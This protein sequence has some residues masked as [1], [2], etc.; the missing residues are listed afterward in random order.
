MALAY[1]PHAD[2][3]ATNLVTGPPAALLEVTDMLGTHSQAAWEESFRA[4]VETSAADMGAIITSL[5]LASSFRNQRP[6]YANAYFVAARDLIDNVKVSYPTIG[7]YTLYTYVDFLVRL[8]ENDPTPGVGKRIMFNY[9]V[10]TTIFN[11]Y[12]PYSGLVGAPG[13]AWSVTNF[14]IYVNFFPGDSDPLAGTGPIGEDFRLAND[15][16]VVASGSSH[17]GDAFDVNYTWVESTGNY[18]TRTSIN[19]SDYDMNEALNPA[20]EAPP[21]TPAQIEAAKQIKRDE[22]DA[23]FGGLVEVDWNLPYWTA[24]YVATKLH[25]LA[26]VYAMRGH[27]ELFYSDAF[28]GR[29]RDI[30][31]TAEATFTLAGN[32]TFFGAFKWF[33][34]QYYNDATPLIRKTYKMVWFDGAAID[35]T[36]PA[37]TPAALNTVSTFYPIDTAVGLRPDVTTGT[38]GTDNPATDEV[39]ICYDKSIVPVTQFADAFDVRMGLEGSIVVD[40]IMVDHTAALELLYDNAST[41]AAMHDLMKFYNHPL[42]IFKDLFFDELKEA[43]NTILSSPLPI[44]PESG[45]VFYTDITDTY[46]DDPSSLPTLV[47]LCCITSTNTSDCTELPAYEVLLITYVS[48]ISYLGQ[49]EVETRKSLNLSDVVHE[50]TDSFLSGDVKAQR[51]WDRS[52]PLL[53]TIASIDTVTPLMMELVAEY[54]DTD[55]DYKF[56]FFLKLKE[57]AEVYVVVSTPTDATLYDFILLMINYCLVSPQLLPYPAELCVYVRSTTNDLVCSGLSA[58]NSILYIYPID[59]SATELV[60]VSDSKS[61]LPPNTVIAE[62]TAKPATNNTGLYLIGGAVVI[63]II[64]V[65][66]VAANQAKTEDNSYS[67]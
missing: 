8:Y 29:C 40:L 25:D 47:E 13:S 27:I 26:V 49:V 41:I 34:E 3:L 32:N 24:G 38:T 17:T 44:V 59:V 58:F 64:V 11:A 48:T 46:I 65:A 30:I 9:S 19:P 67:T 62:P 43:L 5:N 35:T 21:L 54:N 22:A 20:P 36:T 61:A 42:A 14:N 10:G 63:G 57:L 7:G 31:T 6:D 4:G 37:Y 55:D 53:E 45:R 52:I 51:Y 66:G 12:G 39:H 23:L 15:T 16:N 56:G 28:F 18:L 2:I 1:L 60:T 50:N 33:V